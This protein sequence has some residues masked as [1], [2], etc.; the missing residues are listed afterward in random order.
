VENAIRHNPLDGEP[1]VTTRPHRDRVD[2]P[3]DESEQ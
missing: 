3:A 1:W 2:L